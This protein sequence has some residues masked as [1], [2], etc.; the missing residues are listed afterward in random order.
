[1]VDA[2]PA[3]RTARR[4]IRRACGDAAFRAFGYKLSAPD[5]PGQ[6]LVA[7]ADVG[8]ATDGALGQVLQAR[9]PSPVITIPS[10]AVI[11]N[12]GGLQAAVVSD[13]KVEL[14]KIDLDLDNG[15]S[16][17][18]RAGRKPGDHVILS[19]PAISPMACGPGG[20]SSV[21]VRALEDKVSRRSGTELDPGDWR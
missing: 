13:G 2:R 19:P 21:D 16:V 3:L 14:R 10:Q 4:P 1:M 5:Q 17:D 12:Q 20:M 7:L 9:R 11:F 15:A 8:K 18:L 6:T